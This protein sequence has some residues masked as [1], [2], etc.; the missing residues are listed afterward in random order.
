MSWTE[1]V[2]KAAAKEA[3]MLVSK[4]TEQHGAWRTVRN[5]KQRQNKPKEDGKRW[6]LCEVADCRKHN[7][8]RNYWNWDDAST[9]G[10]CLGPRGSAAAEKEHAANEKLAA[11]RKNVAAR[12]ADTGD[13]EKPATKTQARR[14]RAKAVANKNRSP[15]EEDQDKKKEGEDEAMVAEEKDDDASPKPEAL[16]SAAEMKALEDV[17]RD[18]YPLKPG[19][20]SD[21]VIDAQSGNKAV[22]ELEE[23]QAELDDCNTMADF[24][25]RAAKMGVDIKV[26]KARI[27]EIERL[28]AK[29]EKQVTSHRVNAAQLAL[30]KEEYLE[31]HVIKEHNAKKG[32]LKAR[33]AFVQLQLAQQRHLDHWREALQNTAEQEDSRQRLW[34]ERQQLLQDR[35]SRVLKKYDARIAAA[36]QQGEALPQAAQAKKPEELQQAPVSAEAQQ[37]E[38]PWRERSVFFETVS[39]EFDPA[40][41][42]Q[43]GEE[44]LQKPQCLAALGNLH[45]LICY[46][47]NAGAAVP[48][49]FNQLAK[50]TV[51]GADAKE[52]VMRILGDQRDLWYKDGPAQDA[53]LLPRQAVIAIFGVLESAKAKYQNLEQAK[54]SAVTSFAHLTEQHKKR[55][56]APQ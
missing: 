38:T 21:G 4:D 32:A 34:A 27:A 14:K 1:R 16:L 26:T 29:A 19:W 6:W 50:E 20:T 31:L 17:L 28:I 15:G 7:K 51:A 36:A 9:C 44:D 12:N 18:P 10:L 3:V 2:A 13:D 47:M 56:V 11:L 46:W 23:L 48:F 45:Q 37:P 41:M 22:D 55:R 5:S 43:I 25:D 52:L 54:A 40:L 53:D 30:E 49:S 8:G 33:Q 42:P 24:G 35:H 39:L